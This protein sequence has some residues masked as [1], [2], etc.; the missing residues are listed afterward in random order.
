MRRDLESH[1]VQ[2]AD[3]GV[4]FLLL[5]VGI[6]FKG[7]QKHQNCFKYY[8]VLDLRSEGCPIAHTRPVSGC[9]VTTH[10]IA[11]SS[12]LLSPEGLH[13]L[14]H[15]H[16]SLCLA[17]LN[18]GGYG[19]EHATATHHVTAGQTLPHSH[20]AHAHDMATA[21]SPAVYHNG[22][23]A[24]FHLDSSHFLIH[25]SHNTQVRAVTI[26]T[27]VGDVELDNLMGT[28]RLWGAHTSSCSVSSHYMRI[29][30]HL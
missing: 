24:G 11:H 2:S 25:I 9:W 8:L 30:T 17:P 23:V 26:K 7:V 15:I 21:C 18:G 29:P 12:R 4:L 22:P 27:P 20:T 5:N 19:T 13:H 3:V 28:A 14:E 6:C 10:H 16:H 1:K